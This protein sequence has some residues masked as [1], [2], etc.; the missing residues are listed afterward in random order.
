MFPLIAIAGVISAVASVAKGTVWL[1]DKLG[2]TDG[3][4]SPGAKTAAKPQTAARTSPFEAALAAQSAGQTL[5]AGGNGTVAAGAP[6][7]A[8]TVPSTVPATRGTDYDSLARIRAGVAAYGHIGEHRGNHTGAAK[9][10]GADDNQS[11]P[12]TIK[13]QTAASRAL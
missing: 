1:S 6:T 9:A 11:D 10:P 3:S 5:P 2:A 8:A 4:A 7:A 13:A 12:A